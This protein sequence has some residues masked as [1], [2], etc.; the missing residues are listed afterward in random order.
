MQPL[1]RSLW[2]MLI[3][4]WLLGHAAGIISDIQ[5]TMGCIRYAVIVPG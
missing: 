4:A 2:L 1:D 3:Y 5:L